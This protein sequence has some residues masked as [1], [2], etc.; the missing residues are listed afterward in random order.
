M[1]PMMMTGVNSAGSPYQKLSS[2]S[3][4]LK[5]DPIAEFN[6]VRQR[7]IQLADTGRYIVWSDVAAALDSE[8]YDG[9]FVRRI[10]RDN[11]VVGEIN[12][13][14]AKARQGLRANKLSIEKL[15]A[16]AYEL[17]DT[18]RLNHWEEIGAEMENE[19]ADGAI[20]Q[21]G[22]DAMLRRM[23]NARCEQAKAK[24]GT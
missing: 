8:G 23:L 12:Q 16:R 20:A 9:I 18:G 10:G 17:A 11:R 7:A 22:A 15:R 1:P 2:S 4:S 3:R 5:R 14:C 24:L 6:A 19:G 21:I 13:R